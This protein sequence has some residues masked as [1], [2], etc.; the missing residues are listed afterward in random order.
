MYLFNET[1][2]MKFNFFRV[3]L[4]IIDRNKKN[5]TV[6]A[7]VGDSLLDVVIDNNLEFESYGKLY[8]C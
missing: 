7:N 2:H 1:F 5:H 6:S 4:S 3:T 8:L